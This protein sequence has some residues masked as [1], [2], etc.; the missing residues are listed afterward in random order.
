MVSLIKDNQGIP[1][2][3]HIGANV[4]TEHLKVLEEMRAAG[5]MGVEAFSS[6][7][8]AELASKLYDYALGHDLFVTCGSDFHGKNKPKIEVGTCNYDAVAEKSI[9]RFLETALA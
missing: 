7:H 9:R 4:K 1:V 5:V 3:A 8:N 6:Y 2:I